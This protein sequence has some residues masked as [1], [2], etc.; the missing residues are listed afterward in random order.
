[1]VVTVRELD[2]LLREDVRRELEQLHRVLPV[3]AIDINDAFLSSRLFGTGWDDPQMAGY[4][5]W[6][7]LQQIFSWLAVMGWQVI[8]H[9]GVTTRSDLLQRFLQ[10]AANHFPPATLSSWR[11][12]WHWSPQASEAARQ[13]AWRQ[14]REVLHR[15]LPQ[16]QLGIWHR[17][18]ASA[19][20]DDP[21]FH[22]PLLAEADFLACQADANEQLDL[23]QADSSSLA[24]SEHYPA[25]KLRQIHSALRQR[26]LN[27][28]LWLLSWNTLTGDT[29]DTNGR[30]FAARC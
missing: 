26:Q 30:F 2:D 13:A 17:F 14:Q 12:V 15:L 8:L 9:T 27:L 10:L 16:P 3:Y 24:S 21:L 29:R 23:A 6:Y 5:C 18:A 7:N 4:A 20:G 19:P 1:M 28:P 11:F 22:S 25:H